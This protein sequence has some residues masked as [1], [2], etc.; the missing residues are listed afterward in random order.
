MKQLKRVHS[1]SCWPRDAKILAL[2]ISSDQL[3]I[4]FHSFTLSLDDNQNLS[5]VDLKIGETVCN[6]ISP[7]KSVLRIWSDDKTFRESED[8]ARLVGS[9]LEDSSDMPSEEGHYFELTGFCESEWFEL[10]IFADKYELEI[11]DTD[12]QRLNPI[13]E[14]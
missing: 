11:S 14:P 12:Y 1:D 7:R 6:F 5:R 9:T 3:R 4:T 8:L 10:H 2:G 13:T